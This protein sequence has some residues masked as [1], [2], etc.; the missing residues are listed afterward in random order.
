MKY[1]NLLFTHVRLF[2]VIPSA[3]LLLTA[4]GGGGGNSAPVT[5]SLG[6]TVTGLNDDD[7]ELVNN[8]GD[9]LIVAGTSFEFATG[10]ANGSTYE[11]TLQRH[12]S[13]QICSVENGAGTISGADVDS[14][15]VLC[16][17][18]GTAEPIENDNQGDAVTPQTA[19]DD[20]SNVIAVWQH[21]DSP[22]ASNNS[23]YT[24]RYTA[25][26]GW[27][28]AG[29]I[30][31]GTADGDNAKSPEIA[32]DGNGNAIALWW[33]YDASASSSDMVASR[34]TADTGEWGPAVP[35]SDPDEALPSLPNFQVATDNSGNAIAVWEQEDGAGNE[36][37][38]ANFYTADSGW[39]GAGLVENDNAGNASSPD[40]AFDSSGNAIAVWDQD[41]GTRRNI[42]ASVYMAGSDWGTPGLIENDNAGAATAPQIAI[43]GSGNALAIWTQ[44]N[45]TRVRVRV[46]RYTPDGWGTAEWID[47]D[48]A[49]EAYGFS[50]S[51]IAF[52]DS[53][54]AI[55][56]W[57]QDDGER[58]SIWA[59]HYTP[60]SGWGQ[61]SLIE[62][63]NN[64]DAF[65]P[66]IAIDSGGNAMV[67]WS[68]AG[69]TS[70]RDIWA[71]R[72]TPEDGWGEATLLETDNT[73]SAEDPEVIF[74]GSGNAVTVWWQNDGT[75]HN[76]YSNRFE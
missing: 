14:V 53:G 23:A 36:S 76:I 54:N 65:R 73:G 61:A 49:G 27:G 20:N 48:D 28:T 44:N 52:D 37:I 10:L 18:W 67:V 34:Y 25:G 45:G 2:V 29:P 42:R 68:Q 39:E 24:N 51:H 55:A 58:Y 63:N 33:R 35:V 6:G 8:N 3:A 74:D 19:V 5:Y 40:I 50:H 71:N 31:P 16:K 17:S 26:S 4:C 15:S 69:D 59:N 47:N 38:W 46:N 62:N 72:H 12:P 60:E 9:N 56:V 7:L 66:R 22:I 30:M 1:V 11:V 41:D 32:M 70:R 43:D 64:G 75:Q 21:N 57:R 13:T